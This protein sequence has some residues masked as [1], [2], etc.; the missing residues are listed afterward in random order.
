MPKKRY[1]VIFN[2]RI[3]E[4]NKIIKV[5]S[6]KSLSIRS[7][8]FGA[9]SEGIS[10]VTNLLES[11]DVHSTQKFI[12]TLGIKLKKIKKGKYLI[13]GQGLGSLYAPKNTTLDFGNSGTLCRLGSGL[14]ATSPNLNLKL[15][16]DKSL[17]KRNLKKLFDALSKFGAQFYPKNKSYLPIKLISSSIPTGINFVEKKGSAQMIS[18]VTLAGLNTLA[19][20]TK[21]IQ[22]KESRDHTQ[23]FLKNIGADIKIKK[24]KKAKIIEIYGRKKLNNF[25]ASIPG[26]PSSAAFFTALTILQKNSSLKIKNIGLNP[27]RIGFYK[28]LKNHGAKI[29]LKNLRKINKEVVGDII[30]K[31]ST[32]K[33]IRSNSSYY[34]KT[35]DE[36]P[37]LFVIAALNKGLSK[38]TGI[39]GLSNKETNRILEMKELL[40]KVNIKCKSDKDSMT[41]HGIKNLNVGI[42]KVVVNPKL[43]HRI[44]QS[45][46][47]L[48]LATGV[49]ITIK[50]FETVNTSAP[51]FLNRVKQLGG[52][53]EIKKNY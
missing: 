40:K 52:K 30:V 31:S 24:I 14:L 18:A 45:A 1:S 11:E 49:N 25:K 44:C 27:T 23:I 48:A 5:D 6:D 32:I 33:P 39:E 47:I 46:A 15:K 29:K 19:G 41:I 8:L 53:F 21:I 51:S 35:V 20:K 2:K 36:F 7:I 28:I 38:F 12:K 34:S 16:G 26:D 9:I 37:I 50:N 42:K 22:E 3:N 17:Q 13:Y 43:D 10:E 4:Y